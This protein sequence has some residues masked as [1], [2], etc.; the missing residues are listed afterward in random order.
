MMMFTTSRPFYGSTQSFLL[1]RE[2]HLPEAGTDSLLQEGDHSDG[3]CSR[4]RELCV[5]SMLLVMM[6]KKE[7]RIMREDTLLIDVPM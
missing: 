4:A 5:Y 6:L 1:R 3:L 2:I 7:S